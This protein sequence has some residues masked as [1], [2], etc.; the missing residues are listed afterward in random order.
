M[1]NFQRCVWKPYRRSPVFGAAVAN[2]DG[3]SLD[4]ADM[5]CD[6]SQLRLL[7]NFQLNLSDYKFT[8]GVECVD[9]NTVFNEMIFLQIVNT[10]SFC[11]VYIFNTFPYHN[12][13]ASLLFPMLH[14]HFDNFFFHQLT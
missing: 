9:E 8:H 10:K 12:K 4:T 2:T 3:T 11:I 13:K 7:L 1:L 14:F 6:N 5:S